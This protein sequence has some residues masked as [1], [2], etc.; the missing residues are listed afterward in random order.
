M[1][2]F[3]LISA[4]KRGRMPFKIQQFKWNCGEGECWLT[5]LIKTLRKILQFKGIGNPNES[6]NG[7]K[8]ST[9]QMWQIEQMTSNMQRALV[10]RS[11]IAKL[12]RND[13]SIRTQLIPL[14]LIW[15]T[16]P[17]HFLIISLQTK[18]CLKPALP[19]RGYQRYSTS[20]KCFPEK[21][22]VKAFPIGRKSLPNRDISRF[23]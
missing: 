5:C 18:Y 1:P 6:R 11:S 13:I 3:Q 12:V 19:H 21:Q 23:G 2:T 8:R 15:L 9:L 17:K 7:D 16:L 10:T 4:G 14:C 22:L 20:N